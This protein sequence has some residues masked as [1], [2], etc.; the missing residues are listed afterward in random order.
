MLFLVFIEAR[1][2]S[3]V[4]IEVTNNNIAIDENHSEESFLRRLSQS[5]LFF[6]RSDLFFFARVTSNPAA[7]FQIFGIDFDFILVVIFESLD[8]FMLIL[9]YCYCRCLK[10]EAML[11]IIGERL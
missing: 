6:A 9:L 3:S 11:R 2:Y 4:T 8:V 5:F 7:C 1:D 10:I